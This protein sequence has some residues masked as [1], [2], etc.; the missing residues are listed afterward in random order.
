MELHPKQFKDLC[1]HEKHEYAGTLHNGRQLVDIY[2]LIHD[3]SNDI[4]IC[5]REDDKCPSQYRSGSLRYYVQAKC[6]W[7]SQDDPK[8]LKEFCMDT[9]FKSAVLSLF[10]KWAEENKIKINPGQFT[11]MHFEKSFALIKQEL[12]GA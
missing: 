1:E 7:R 5:I 12:E 2:F 11:H 4:G 10:F 3:I 6:G 9:E 8:M